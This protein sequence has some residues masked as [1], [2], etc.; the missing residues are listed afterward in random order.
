MRIRLSRTRS[1]LLAAVALLLPLDIWYL[2]ARSRLN[3]PEAFIY[4][5]R[6]YVAD[7]ETGGHWPSIAADGSWIDGGRRVDLK[8]LEEHRG[9]GVDGGP[10]SLVRISLG[11]DASYGHFLNSLRGLPR[12]RKCTYIIHERGS[13]EAV[14][15]DIVVHSVAEVRDPG[16]GAMITCMP[17]PFM[18]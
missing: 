8:K 15:P 16:T 13:D 9:P 14:G 18:L 5:W 2:I 1:I 4:L 6:D 17:R 3:Q 7:D 10:A 11:S 12:A